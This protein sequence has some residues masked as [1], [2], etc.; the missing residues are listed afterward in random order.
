MI[1]YIIILLVIILSRTTIS[2]QN[3]TIALKLIDN[4]CGDTW[5]EGEF[6]YRFNH[7]EFLAASNHT[8]L[9][10]EIMINDEKRFKTQCKIQGF[11]NFKEITDI[12][13]NRPK[14]TDEFYDELNKC[15]TEKETVFKSLLKL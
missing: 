9:K 15:I 13:H 2:N 7:I 5:C 10:F 4:I 1:K 8:L 6:N 14:I 3:D 12:V 11:S